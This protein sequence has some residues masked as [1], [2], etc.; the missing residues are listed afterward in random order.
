MIR[1]FRQQVVE[2]ALLY[3]GALPDTTSV[4]NIVLS[5]LPKSNIQGEQ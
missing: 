1:L 2:Q 3:V 5:V 4:R